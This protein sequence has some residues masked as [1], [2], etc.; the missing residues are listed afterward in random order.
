MN[1]ETGHEKTRQVKQGGSQNTLQHSPHRRV[2]THTW[3]QE[4]ST[5]VLYPRPQFCSDCQ[6]GTKPVNCQKQQ[7][8]TND[9]LDSSPYYS[10]QQLQLLPVKGSHLQSQNPRV[11]WICIF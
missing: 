4:D 9:A 5:P 6:V 10:F 2:T 8:V 3:H 7:V 1:E 11:L